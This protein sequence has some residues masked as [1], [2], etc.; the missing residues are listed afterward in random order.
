MESL[1]RLIASKKR[2]GRLKGLRMN[3]IFHLTHLLFVDDLLIFL[4][5]NIR[6][7]ATFHE[8]LILFEKATGMITNQTK[9][10]IT[11]TLTTPQEVRVAQMYFH[12]TPLNLSDGL[13]YFGFRIK[14]NSYRISD[15]I[16]LLIK[17][18]KRL[19]SW[20]HRMLSRAGSLILIKSIMEATSVY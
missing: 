6:D 10:M 17:L 20:N 11:L 14:P 12:Y 8:I 2:E 19:K 16:W 13:K 5:G 4:N 7:S 15:W 9:P 3:D 18:E 1:S